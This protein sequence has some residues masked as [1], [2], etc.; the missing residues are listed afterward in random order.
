MTSDTPQ[1]Q[2]E[3]T[4]RQAMATSP[5]TGGRAGR[6][7]SRVLADGAYASVGATDRL[8]CFVRSL[9]DYAVRISARGPQGFRGAV[10]QQFDSL[11]I[12]GREVVDAISSSPTT[13]R[14]VEQSKTAREQFL[15]A[16]GQLRRTRGD[17]NRAA[18]E[19]VEAVED[20]A[21]EIGSQRDQEGKT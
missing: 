21:V 3:T 5:Q 4:N 8:V 7:A 10:E 13:Q 16:A 18:G 6:T 15:T 11:V 1:H 17:A 9:P 12:R 14:A 19:T 2:A 20:A